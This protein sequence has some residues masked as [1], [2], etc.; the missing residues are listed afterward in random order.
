MF[1]EVGHEGCPLYTRREAE[2]GK[3]FVSSLVRFSSCVITNDR[4]V[5][6]S[7]HSSRSLP[8]SNPNSRE[9]YRSLAARAWFNGYGDAV[10]LTTDVKDDVPSEPSARDQHGEPQKPQL[11]RSLLDLVN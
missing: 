4:D 3:S 6:A 1:W 8:D 11:V 2:K 5:S 9:S 7:V 10:R